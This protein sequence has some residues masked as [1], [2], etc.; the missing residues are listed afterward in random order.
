MGCKGFVSIVV[1]VVQVCAVVVILLCEE[2][3]M[4]FLVFAL[5]DRGG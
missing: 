3:R 5:I 1:P 2:T 4:L